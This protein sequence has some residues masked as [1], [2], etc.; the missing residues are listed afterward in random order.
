MSR[1]EDASRPE[2][3]ETTMGR[4]YALNLPWSASTALFAYCTRVCRADGTNSSR[5]GRRPVRGHPDR[6]RPSG[7]CPTEECPRCREVTPAGQ[8]D[9]DDLSVLVNRPVQIRPTTGDLDVRLVD[10]PSVTRGPRSPSWARFSMTALQGGRCA[11]AAQDHRF[12]TALPRQL[13]VGHF[14]GP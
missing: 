13:T 5:I 3:L 7:E 10:E 8:P 1:G 2:S 12:I 6:H 4:R 11:T 14:A 9:V